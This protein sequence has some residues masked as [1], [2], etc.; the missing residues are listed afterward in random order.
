MLYFAL[1][2]VTIFSLSIPAF[3]S[4]LEIEGCSVEIIPNEIIDEQ[5]P[6]ELLAALMENEIMPYG[7]SAPSSGNTY[8][9]ANGAY[10]FSVSTKL[11][12]T[13]YSNYVFTGHGGSV[14]VYLNDTS[15]ASGSY[16]FKIYKR[17][18][19]DTTVYTRTCNHD[20]TAKF[21]TNVGDADSKIFFAVVPKGTTYI[22]ENSYIAKG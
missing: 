10:N 5:L 20:D 16:Q 8:N 7:Q 19:I 6:A 2:I 13:I 9:L 15:T 11:N 21:T 12:T 18:L 4:A 17:G 3:A 1:V 22:G 14:S